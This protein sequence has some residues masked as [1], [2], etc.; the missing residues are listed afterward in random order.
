M[1]RTEVC[2]LL[3]QHAFERLLGF[4]EFAFRHVTVTHFM[5]GV[6]SFLDVRL[7]LYKIFEHLQ[8]LIVVPL[9]YET[10]TDTVVRAQC[11]S[12]VFTYFSHL[13]LEYLVEYL[14]RT[15]APRLIHVTHTNT[16]HCIQSVGV[17]LSKVVLL[18]LQKFFKHSNCVVRTNGI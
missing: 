15:L 13:L 1:M 7:L 5:D 6:Q 17:R 2:D 16:M 12:F 9:S 10:S 3:V 14:Q 18:S 8:R 4:H 11:T